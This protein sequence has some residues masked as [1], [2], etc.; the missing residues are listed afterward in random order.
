MN[1]MTLFIRVRNIYN[2]PRVFGEIYS[3]VTTNSDKFF[4]WIINVVIKVLRLL[5]NLRFIRARF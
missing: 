1:I 2:F 4:T 3:I 5:I